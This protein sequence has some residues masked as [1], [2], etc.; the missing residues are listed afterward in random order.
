MYFH[1][2]CHFSIPEDF[3]LFPT[4]ISFPIIKCVMCCGSKLTNFLGKQLLQ[5]ICEPASIKEII[6]W[7]F[8]FYF[9]VELGG[10]TKHSITGPMV[11]S[12]FCFLL[13]LMQH[14]NIRVMRKQNLLFPLRPVIRCL[15]QVKCSGKLYMIHK[16]L[17]QTLTFSL[18]TF[19]P[20]SQGKN[21]ISYY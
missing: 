20:V 1:F 11:H 3:L 9:F 5:Q 2:V 14:W 7:Q 18:L 12:E 10:I 21:E 4:Q 19:R 8:F 6:S 13:V 17:F 16:P 15:F